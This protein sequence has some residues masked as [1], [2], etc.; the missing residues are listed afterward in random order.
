MALIA[1]FALSLGVGAASANRSLAPTRTLLTA[2]S[3]EVSFTSESGVRIICPV[4]LTISLHA[5]ISKVRGSLAGY[6]TRGT[7]GEALCRNNAGIIARARLL[8]RTLPWHLLYQSFAGTLPRLLT[9]VLAL[10]SR[11]G[12]LIELE[13]GTRR[14]TSCSYQGDI[15]AAFQAAVA[16]TFERIVVLLPNNVP[17]TVI[18]EEQ[19]GRCPLRGELNATFTFGTTRGFTLL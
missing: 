15:P 8:V 19:V 18:L 7:V 3:P 9:S 6:V 2:V 13:D 10:V 11:A 1:T 17:L 16:G 5:R 4:T 14:I 12:F